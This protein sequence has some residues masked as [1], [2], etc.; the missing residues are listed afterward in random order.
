MSDGENSHRNRLVERLRELDLQ[1]EQEMRARGF[2]PAQSEN[3]ALTA[4]LA[5]LYTERENL[6]ALLK[7][8]EEAHA[9]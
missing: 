8:E 3:A 6:R 1:Y 9:E 2:D 4:T 7:I 5:K